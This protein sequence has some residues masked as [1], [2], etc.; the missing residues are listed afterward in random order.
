MKLVTHRM[1]D[2]L[3]EEAGKTGRLR[4]HYNIHES[5][6]DPVQRLFVAAGRASYFRP[7]R[8]PGKSEFAI[9]L[10]GLFDVILFNGEGTVTDRISAGP[11]LD[12]FALE[13]PADVYHTWIPRA[14]HSAFFEVK[15]GP[16]DPATSLDFAPWSP[17]E[18][19]AGVAEFQAKL[20]ALCPGDRIA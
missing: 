5:L 16:Y 8:H 2:E 12:I 17:A 7:H 9:I 14:E 13:V 1:V 11:G 19:A 10:R 4:T 6:S 20:L 3:I 18:G 15:Q